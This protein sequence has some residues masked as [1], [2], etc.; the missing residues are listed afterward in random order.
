[1]L[2]TDRALKKEFGNKRGGTEGQVMPYVGSN[3]E[4][5]LLYPKMCT[6][7]MDF[8]AEAEKLRTLCNLQSF[9]SRY[10]ITVGIDSAEH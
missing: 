6:K 5:L 9:P 2:L 7:F 8:V 1:M 10:I 3:I 4:L